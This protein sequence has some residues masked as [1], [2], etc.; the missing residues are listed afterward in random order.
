MG[1][2]TFTC[3]TVEIFGASK[4]LKKKN[5]SAMMHQINQETDLF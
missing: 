2:L 3:A 5:N 4:I 1:I